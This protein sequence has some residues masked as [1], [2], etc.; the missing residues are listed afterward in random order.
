[1]VGTRF[2]NRGRTRYAIALT[3]VGSC[4]L[5]L[6]GPAGAARRTPTPLAGAKLPPGLAQVLPPGTAEAAKPLPRKKGT[7][8][9]R[10][11][12]HVTRRTA[13]APS[14]GPSK[15]RLASVNLP[16][17]GP[18]PA[19]VT[20]TTDSVALRALIVAVDAGDFGVPT[21][22]ST[23]DRVGA[24]YDVL[25]TRD[26]PLTADTLVNPNGVGRY[27][28]ILLTNSMLLYADSAGNY[29]SGLNADQ[30]NL[31]WAYERDYGVRQATLYSSYG[32]FPEDYC[33]R[34]GTEGPVDAT[35]LP[36]SLT[37]AGAAVFDNLKSTAKI[38]IVQSY[39]YRTT[40][41][42]GCS[43]QAIL[44]NGKSVLGVQTTSTDGRER[45]ALTFTSNQY[46]MQANLL[47]YGLYRWASRGV[48]LGE[49]RHFLDMDVDDWFNT[50]DE[51]LAT[52]VLNSDPGW[53]MTAHDAYNAYQRQT[54]LRKQYPLASRFTFGLAYNGSDANL[55][56]G[57]SCSPNGGIN[58][59]TATSRCL[60]DQFTW[61]NHTAS[62]PKLNVT[63]YATTS[64]EIA[65]NLAI[66]KTLGLPVDATVLKTPE[67]SG[68]GT[69]NDDPND[70]ISPPTDH[71]LLAS[72]PAMLQAAKD[73]GVKYLHGNMSFPSQVP[74]CFDCAITHP[75]EPSLQ[76]VPDWPTNIAYFSTT[77]AEETYFYNSFYGPT[78]RF[79]YW[80]QNLTYTQLMDYETDI[81]LGH[82]ATGSVYTHTFHIANLR[83]YGSGKTLA[84]DWATS[85]IAKYSTYYKV[86]LL[87]PGW[88][89]LAKYA[90]A[91]SAHFAA[92]SGG[93]EAVYNRTA[94]TVTVTS[95]VAATVTVSGATTAGYSAYGAEV[96]APITVAAGGS[97]VFVPTVRS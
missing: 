16:A 23:L 92:L 79:P 45:V 82:L 84:T 43:A 4:L 80:S 17:L 44:T 15:G 66:A 39:V 30:W 10:P 69:Y 95:P 3:I 5:A 29:L 24:G 22:K 19:A 58:Q 62:H 96:S 50:A 8:A 83:D 59:L 47:T 68:L 41:A 13:A 6:P 31:L 18:V 26:T 93:V 74:L 35:A 51:L 97:A 56:A 52:G 63:D 86:P 90:S 71:G 38:P 75:M 12:E 34:A 88:P 40:I 65:N 60:K 55:R 46:L 64:A 48:Y 61:I 78:G 70:D 36:A 20:G 9:V 32:A 49:Q 73:L 1:M 7:V 28:A 77:P 53:Q 85:L 87:C 33:T 42:A 89:A 21:W 67:Y 94:R 11:D 81:A 91:R 54:A 25:Y 76:I 2:F 14:G 57:S 37:A 72:N 27:N